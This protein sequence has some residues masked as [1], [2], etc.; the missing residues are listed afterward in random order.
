VLNDNPSPAEAIVKV[1]RQADDDPQQGFAVMVMTHDQPGLFARITGYFEKLAFDIAAAKIY[2]TAHDYALD[3]FQILPKSDSAGRY[4]DVVGMIER[5]L[6]RLL[7]DPMAPLS[8]HSGR[9][10]RQVKH[11]PM[12]PAITLNPSRRKP[13]FELAVSC[14]DRPGLL[15]AI[16][17]VFLAFNVNLHDARITTLGQRAED[18]FILAHPQL[19]NVEFAR[20]FQA[21]LTTE[22]R[23]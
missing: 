21:R 2:T 12:E 6:A 17:R 8:P 7:N 5:E 19:G 4:R 3:V 23:P 9:V 22:L 11:F 16:A 15:S 1:R 10:S 20:E 14:A 13:Y 18:V